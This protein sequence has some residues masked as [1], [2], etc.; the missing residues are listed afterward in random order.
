M[1]MPRTHIQDESGDYN[2]LL[3]MLHY[4]MISE[5]GETSSVRW[6]GR[7]Y[8]FFICGCAIMCM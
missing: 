8:K 7:I 6:R 5:V 1:S 3:Q 2:D 4:T